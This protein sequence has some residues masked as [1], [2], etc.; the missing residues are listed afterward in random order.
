M[1]IGR[2]E[3]AE[4]HDIKVGPA[5]VNIASDITIQNTIPPTKAFQQL[6]NC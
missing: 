3:G 5:L 2:Q 1:A 4:Q 6:H